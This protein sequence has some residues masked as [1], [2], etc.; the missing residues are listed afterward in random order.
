MKKL[1]LSNNQLSSYGLA[2]IA[3]ALEV[4]NT[5]TDLDIR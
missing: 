4:N 1:D 3:H 5:L 2:F